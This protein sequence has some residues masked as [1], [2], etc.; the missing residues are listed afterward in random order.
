MKRI[1]QNL[2]FFEDCPDGRWGTDCSKAC[3]CDDHSSGCDAVTGECLCLPGWYGHRCEQGKSAEN[4]IFRIIWHNMHAHYLCIV[5]NWK[6]FLIYWACYQKYWFSKYVS[7]IYKTVYLQSV[8]L[9]DTDPSVSSVV[10]ARME[11][12]VIRQMADVTAPR[13]GWVKCA[14]NVSTQDHYIQCL[15]LSESLDKISVKFHFKILT[16]QNRSRNIPF[17]L[18]MDGAMKWNM[19]LIRRNFYQ[20]LIIW[21]KI[22][23]R[24]FVSNV[25][26]STILSM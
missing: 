16:I 23:I 22:Y 3:L 9:I 11:P 14:I 1:F 20:V 17:Y 10:P 5:L 15:Y 21:K 24:N 2:Y 18:I 12:G 6:Y 26:R 25:H 4:F 7:I 13:A 19:K 8:R